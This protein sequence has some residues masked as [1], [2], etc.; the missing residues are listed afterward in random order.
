MIFF[1]VEVSRL[2]IVVAPGRKA[3]AVLSVWVTG[4][5]VGTT[6]HLQWGSIVIRHCV[7]SEVA[8]DSLSTGLPL[9]V[10]TG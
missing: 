6:V 3:V 1:L 10:T 9:T 2:G 7:V 5:I 4:M 8:I